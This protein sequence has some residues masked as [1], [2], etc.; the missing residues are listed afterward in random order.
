MDPSGF[1]VTRM[2]FVVLDQK[3]GIENLESLDAVFFF[4]PHDN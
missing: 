4:W 1:G 2:R 3:V